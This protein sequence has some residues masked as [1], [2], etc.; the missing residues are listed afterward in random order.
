MNSEKSEGRKWGVRS[1]VVGSGVFGAP[2]FSVQRSEI[3]IFKGF[4]D[5]WTEKR[6][7]PKT[8]KSTTTDLTPHLRPSEKS[9]MSV[10]FR[11]QFEGR[12]WLREFYGRLGFVGS[13]CRKTLHAHNI[14]HFGG[15]LGFLLGGES[16]EAQQRYFKISRD[17]CSDSIDRKTLSC[18]F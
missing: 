9:L 16:L 10:T 11:P 8:P 17:I 18:L 12:S 5:L 3:P 15:V 13:F 14:P 1:V 7:A 6:G 4:W 2:R